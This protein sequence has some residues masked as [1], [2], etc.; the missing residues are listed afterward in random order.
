VGGWVL[1]ATAFAIGAT[2]AKDIIQN[3]LAVAFFWYPISAIFAFNALASMHGPG[4]S[5]GGLRVLSWLM[6]AAWVVLALAVEGIG[7]YSR[8]TSPMHAILLAAAAAYT[9]ITR[10][11]ASRTDLLRDP[12]FVTAAFWVIYA[13]P[14][15]FLSVAA[16]FWMTM[17]NSEQLLNYYSFR[18]TIV[19]LSYGILLY[20]ISLWAGIRP[21]RRWSVPTEMSG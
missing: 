15:V 7:E 1:S 9:L 11:E 14:T 17:E 2:I 4:R 8:V 19:I 21:P 16:R 13:V 3:S 18:N 5:R 6:I 12:A 10:V 20:G